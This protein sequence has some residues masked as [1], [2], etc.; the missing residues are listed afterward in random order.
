MKN[1]KAIPIFLILIGLIVALTAPASAAA[2]ERTLSSWSAEEV[3]RAEAYGLLPLSPLVED[4]E[5]MEAAVITDWRQPI[6]RAQ[7]IRFAL[8]YAAAMNRCDEGTFRGLVRDYLAEKTDD[9]YFLIMPFSD[10]RTEDV[11]LA[12]ALG[13]AKGRGN[14]IFDPNAPITRQEA[15]A[16]LYRVYAACGGMGEEDIASPFADE[17][18]I[19]D[20]AAEAVHALRQRD[21]LRG[22]GN[23]VFDPDGSFT[24]EQ[25]AVTF[26]RL[27]EQMPVSRLRGT[28]V[29]LFDR[30]KCIQSV[31]GNKYEALR[32]EGPAATL[33]ATDFGAMHATRNYYLIY[34]EG[35]VRHIAPAVNVWYQDFY[36]EDPAFSEDGRTLIYT[37]TLERELSHLD[38]TTQLVVLDFAPGVYHAV[39][40]VE[41]GNQTVTVTP[42]PE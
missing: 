42:L 38:E 37:I 11:A 14:G 6:T 3:Q 12:Y 23:N 21:V 34:P 25:C 5:A 2:E 13:L 29:P 27:Y 8:S 28:A 35:G 10:D 22:I 16:F 18:K 15:A 33:L 4:Y 41:T 31:I 24:V 1:R 30:E 20:W 9:G 19:A 39:V 7:F 36:M 26:L 17:D 40:D 32:L